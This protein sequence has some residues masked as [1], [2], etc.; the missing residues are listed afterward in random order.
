MPLLVPMSERKVGEVQPSS[1]TAPTSSSME[2]PG[3]CIPRDSHPEQAEIANLGDN[4]G[5]MRSPLLQ[6]ALPLGPGARARAGEVCS[7]V[8]RTIPRPGSLQD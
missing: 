8:D 5:G 2:S 6:P 3:R 4:L 1:K 7:A